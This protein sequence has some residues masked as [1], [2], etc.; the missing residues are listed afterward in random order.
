MF[1]S[2]CLQAEETNELLWEN[3]HE[4]AQAMV[5][6]NAYLDENF[7]QGKLGG[8]GF[9][10]HEMASKEEV[11]RE[12]DEI[13]SDK[14]DYILNYITLFDSETWERLGL[15]HE[16]RVVLICNADRVWKTHCQYD[17]AFI[18]KKVEYN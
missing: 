14:P 1:S 18:L 8:C 12:V 2:L 9:L 11:D 10:S 6:V 17:I 3:M 15:E 13:I 5:E 7:L 4:F 16:Y